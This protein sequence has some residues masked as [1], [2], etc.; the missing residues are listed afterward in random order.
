MPSH[1]VDVKVLAYVNR[2]RKQLGRRPLKRL[3]KGEVCCAESCPI[4]RALKPTDGYAEVDDT[5]IVVVRGAGFDAREVLKTKPPRYVTRF[6]RHF[7][8]GL[9]PELVSR[10][11][12]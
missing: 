12:G 6:V 10:R 3:P 7:D 1:S 11:R 5:E 8:N 4:A 9:I 2:L